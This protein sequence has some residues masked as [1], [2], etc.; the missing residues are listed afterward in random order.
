MPYYSFREIWTPL[1][2]LGIRFFKENHEGRYW[3]K[4]GKNSKKPFFKS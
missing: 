2:W 1:K 3:I 4:I